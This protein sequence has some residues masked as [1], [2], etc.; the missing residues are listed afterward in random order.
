MSYIYEYIYMSILRYCL[1]YWIISN[2]QECVCERETNSGQ[3]LVYGWGKLLRCNME[4]CVQQVQWIG[5]TI[6]NNDSFSI[7]NTKRTLLIRVAKKTTLWCICNYI[8]GNCYTVLLN[9]FVNCRRPLSKPLFVGGI[10][11]SFDLCNRCDYRVWHT[12]VLEM[13]TGFRKKNC[14]N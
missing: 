4:T 5:I 8:G 7:Y 2:M 1:M 12:T 6:K 10:F 9:L 13:S 14:R 3:E 11:H